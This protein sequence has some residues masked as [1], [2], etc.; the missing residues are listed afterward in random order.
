MRP[1]RGTREGESGRHGR[2]QEQEGATT[3][4]DDAKR[5]IERMA[6][7]DA[8]REKILAA[9]D[10]AG[11]LELAKAEG[12]DVG[13][14]EIQGASAELADAELDGVAAGGWGDACPT[15][16]IHH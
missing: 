5:L 2:A 11:R 3:S 1:P 9:P 14:E 15:L 13:E 4:Y 6:T 12:Y 16:C 7:D 8:L 10:T